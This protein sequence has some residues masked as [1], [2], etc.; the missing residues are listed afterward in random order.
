MVP[1]LIGGPKGPKRRRG[2]SRSAVLYAAG[3]CGPLCAG[4]GS[5]VG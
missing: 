4:E 5:G 1:E 2:Q 3:P